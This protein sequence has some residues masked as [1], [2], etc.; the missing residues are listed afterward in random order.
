M[1]TIKN[2]VP[3]TPSRN[4]HFEKTKLRTYFDEVADLS[5]HS[6]SSSYLLGDAQLSL[7]GNND[8]QSSIPDEV[9]NAHLV[10]FETFTTNPSIVND[11]NLVVRIAGK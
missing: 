6:R 2:Q 9:F 1:T 5:L 4:H 7:C 11:P 8:K 3:G 10:S